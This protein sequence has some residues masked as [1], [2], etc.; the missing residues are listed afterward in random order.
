MIVGSKLQ[1]L[2]E[3]NSKATSLLLGLFSLR[4]HRALEI[5]LLVAC[6]CVA[7]Q[8]RAFHDPTKF[9]L[10]PEND[11]LKGGSGGRVYTGSPADGYACTVCHGPG[12]PVSYRLLGLPT[13]GY[14]PGQ[15]YT[16]TVD[17]TEILE[18]VAFNA[19]FTDAAGNTIG[20]LAMPP[21]EMLLPDDLCETGDPA[22]KV[23]PTPDGRQVVLSPACKQ[24]QGTFQWTAPAAGGGT[25]FFSG[26][27]VVSNADAEITGDR[28]IVFSR[29]M[30]P[31]GKE[32]P[33]A[34]H[35]E[36]LT[37]QCTLSNPG[38]KGPPQ[39]WLVLAVPLL[40]AV[41]RRRAR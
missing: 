12:K 28:A 14:V 32:S 15:T 35:V 23:G 20:T 9:I 3:P 17:W 30:A 36:G 19:E 33:D 6:V 40:L 2:I 5:S 38:A 11:V 37:K 29:T 41:L 22:A 8:A 10:V 7:G 34:A 27:L 21:M 16:V 4:F 31:V 13:G 18:A 1:G 24:Q 25:A 26:S 39:G